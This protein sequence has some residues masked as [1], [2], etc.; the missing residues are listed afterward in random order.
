MKGS[1][2]DDIAFLKDEFP[3]FLEKFTCYE[4]DRHV[5]YL[6]GDGRC[7]QCTRLS[8]DEVTGDYQD[9]N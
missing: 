8:V 4:C 5:P 9:E 6:F 2:L 1:Y 3:Q 7:S